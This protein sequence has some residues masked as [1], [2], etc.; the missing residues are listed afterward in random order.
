[1]ARRA[2]ARSR[3]QHAP[4]SV[5]YRI[6]PRSPSAPSAAPRSDPPERGA[7]WHPAIA[8][9]SETRATSIAVWLLRAVMA[10][11]V[12]FALITR[13][14]LPALAGLVALGLSFT[15]RLVGRATSMGVPGWIEL[16]WVLAVALPGASTAFDLYDR[17][18]HWGK[19]VHGADGL[20]V[21]LLF[22]S[23]LLGYRDDRLVDLT[24]QL[25]SLTAM[26]AG[27]AFGVAWEIIEFV[28]DWVADT[29]LQKSNSDTMTDFL[30]NDLGAVIGALLAVRLYRRW[31][32]AQDRRALGRAGW[33]L[34][35]GPSRL[36]DRHG[37]LMTA[38]AVVVIALAIGALW[39][40]GRPVPGLPT[41]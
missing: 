35:D 26:F 20:L 17:V 23:L 41:D 39:F 1:M 9:A 29:S 8:E 11:G 40:A 13:Q 14:P 25:S 19:F 37:W 2:A 28:I 30:W 22:G 32:P 34:V 6:A 7:R 16:L 38:V 21:A 4:R 5:E 15:P 24:D 27:I 10:A 36:L 3:R 31:A 33:W 18:T 12:L